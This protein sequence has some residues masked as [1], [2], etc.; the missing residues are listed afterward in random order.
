M[1]DSNRYFLTEDEAHILQ[2]ILHKNIKGIYKD[3]FL[4]ILIIFDDGGLWIKS[5]PELGYAWDQNNETK[6]IGIMKIAVREASL[7]EIGKIAIAENDLLHCSEIETVQIV[8]SVL[9]FSNPKVLPPTNVGKIQIDRPGMSYNYQLFNPHTNSIAELADEKIFN[10]TDLGLFFTCKNG[11]QLL[12]WNDG[13][14]NVI[15]L[16]TCLPDNF[17]KI[18]S[19]IP[20]NH[21]LPES[22][23]I[24]LTKKQ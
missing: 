12:I 14:S 10:K 4:S 2:T 23:T 5:S 24:I 19:L 13:W 9:L 15:K 11:E 6:E 22:Q 1:P 16:E 3:A 17:N 20:L 7:S 21:R 18:A 8:N